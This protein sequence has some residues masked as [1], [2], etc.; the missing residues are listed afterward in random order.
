MFGVD[1]VGPSD[2]IFIAAAMNTKGVTQ[3]FDGIAL[4][5]FL[6]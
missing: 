1:G 3:S 6:N 2:P 5:E 4:I